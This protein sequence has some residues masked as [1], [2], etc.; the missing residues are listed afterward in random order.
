MTNIN[1]KV[2]GTANVSQMHGAFG[3]LEA[4]IAATNAQL[5]SMVNLQKG[6][7]GAGF[8][9]AAHAA[10]IGN[11]AF[12]NAAASTGMFEQMQLRVNS[13][14]DDYVKK[15]NAQ[16]LSFRDMIKQRKIAAAVL[17]E[18]I[19]LENSLMVRSDGSRNSRGRQLFDVS[20]AREVSS[21]LKTS[22]ARMALFNEQLKSG[23]HQMVNWGKNT[24]WA[25]RQLMVGFTIPMAA[26]AATAGVFAYQVDK[27]LTRI[28]KVYDTTAN[29]MSNNAKD[30]MAVEKELMAL[31]EDAMETTLKAAREYGA[32]GTDTL[33]VQADLAATGIKGVELQKATTEAMRIATLGELDYQQAVDTTIALQTAF[34]LNT[35]EL[36]EAFNFMNATENATSLSIQDIAEATPRAASAMSALGVSVEQMTVLLVAMRESG[37]DAAEAA[38]ALKS[39]TGT[40]LAPSPSADKFIKQ[41]TDGR[42]EI[43]KLAEASG[44]NLF[45]AMQQLFEQMRGLEQFEKQQILVKLFGKYQFNR[46]SALLYN[47]SDAIEG[48]ENQTHT[49]FE[50][51]GKDTADFAKTA[52]IELKRYQD[53]VS[54]RFDTTLQELKVKMAGVGE[55]FVEIATVVLKSVSKILDIFES[56]PGPVQ[57]T[58]GVILGMAAL[59]GPVIMLTG[60]FANLMGNAVKLGANVVGLGTKMKILD[61]ESRVAQLAAEKLNTTYLKET[62]AVQMLTAEIEK[63][64]LAQKEANIVMMQATGVPVP[65]SVSLN[66]PEKL[67]NGKTV[68]VANG[69]AKASERTAEANKRTS[70]AMRA[71][72]A[73]AAILATSFVAMSNTSDGIAH[74]ISQWVLNAS[75]MAPIIIEIT[76]QM[77]KARA[78]QRAMNAEAAASNVGLMAKLRGATGIGGKG[79][80]IGL[81]IAGIAAA[82][83]TAHHFW[84]KSREEAEKL[85]AIRQKQ[86]KGQTELL[87]VT[88]SWAKATGKTLEN[89]K[90][91]SY[92]SGKILSDAQKTAYQ[93]SFDLYSKG[94]GKEESKAFGELDADR[95][96]V[97]LML[98]FTELTQRAGLSIEEARTQML[99]FSAAS[100][101]SLA[102]ANSQI[103]AFFSTV[104]G[105]GDKKIIS[106]AY[107]QQMDTFLDLVSEG[108]DEKI[109]KA[110]G[111]KAG[112]LWAAAFSQVGKNKQAQLGKQLIEETSRV[113]EESFNKIRQQYLDSFGTRAYDS[114]SSE[115]RMMLS[116]YEKFKDAWD[117]GSLMEEL[118]KLKGI[119]SG[120]GF[121]DVTKIAEELTVAA[122][123]W[124][125]SS[126]AAE[127]SLLKGLKNVGLIADEVK[128]LRQAFADPYVFRF[129]GKEQQDS[130]LSEEVSRFIK[131]KQ[132]L[133]S[134]SEVMPSFF[135][136]KGVQEN[137]DAMKEKLRELINAA[138][139][140]RGFA[141]GATYEEAMANLINETKAAKSEVDNLKKAANDASGNYKMYFDIRGADSATIAKMA[142]QAM[143]DIQNQ[144][145]D[146]YRDALDARQEAA[147][148][149]RQAFWDKQAEAQEKK[150]DRESEAQ[151]KRFERQDKKLDA[152]FE[153]RTDKAEKYWDSRI[154][155]VDKA[156]EAEEAA[157]DLRKKMFDAEMQRIS[158]LNDSMNRNIDFNVALNEGRLD[159]AAKIRN[160]IFSTATSSALE[161]ARDAGSSASEARVKSLKENIDGLEEER[162]AYMDNLKKKEEAEKEHLK[163]SQERQS[164]ALKNQQDAQSKALKA[165][166]D[167]DIKSLRRA[168]EAEQTSLQQRLAMFMNYIAQNEGDLKRHMGNVGLTYEE[169][170]N[171][172]LHPK[173]DKWGGWYGKAMKRS[174]KNAALEME[175]DAMWEQLA[176]VSVKKLV[177]GMGFK[178]KKQFFQFVEDAVG[179]NAGS[180]AGDFGA[181]PTRH[182]GGMINSDPG[183]RKGVAR[184]TRGL[185]PTERMIRAQDGEFMVNKRA[186]AENLGLLTRINSGE[187]FG[188]D[189]GIGGGF[190]GGPLG[191]AS[192]PMAGISYALLAGIA[193]NLRKSKTDIDNDMASASYSGA[194]GN[195]TYTLPGVKPWVFEAAQYLGNKFDIAS[196]LG[197]GSRSRMSDHPLGLAL[198]FMTSDNRGTA[199]ANEV[200]RINKALDSTYVIWRQ[201]INSFDGQGWRPMA[202][203]GSPTE[204]HM[205]HVHVSFKP[206]GK[207]GDL[208]GLSTATGDFKQGTGGKHRPVNGG[209]ITQGLHGNNAVDFGVPRG[210]PV[211]AYADGI[212]SSSRDI[213]GPLP[214]DRYRGDGPYG[215]YGRVIEIN[216]GGFSTMYAHLGQRYA[217]TGQA[218]KGGAKIGLS[219]NTGNSSGP[220]LHFGMPGARMPAAFL[221]KG[222]TVKNDGTPAILHKDE[223]V[224]TAPLTKK[225]DLAVDALYNGRF[226]IGGKGDDKKKKKKNKKG[227]YD[228]P[229]YLGAWESI[230]TPQNVSPVPTPAAP[231]PIPTAWLMNTPFT[232]PEQMASSANSPHTW[233][234]YSSDDPK[235]EDTTSNSNPNSGIDSDDLASTIAGNTSTVLN[236]KF[237][238][239]I[240][241]LN[242]K[243]DVPA[244]QTITDIKKLI[245]MADVMTL[246]EMTRKVGPVRDFL[247]KKG[248]GLFSGTSKADKANMSVIAYNKAKYEASE[249]GTQKLG[250]KMG[251]FLGGREYRYANY[252][253][254]RNKETG[255][256][257]WQIAAHTVPT[258]GPNLKGKRLAMYNEQWSALDDLV[259]R[260][261]GTGLPV[262]L[263]GD[264]NNAPGQKGWRTPGGLDKYSGRNVDYIFSNPKLAKLISEQAINGMHTDHAGAWLA[265]YKIPSLSKGA[266]DVRY[267]DTLANLHR[268]E[269]VLT[270]DINSQ[271]RQGVENFANG[272][273]NQYTVQ[274]SITE[275]GATADEI[276]NK[277][278]TKLER[279]ES[280]RPGSRRNS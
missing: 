57:K 233:F 41:V 242:T 77:A 46:V 189:F 68:A 2:V 21:E 145:A 196:I 182:A 203:R 117:N 205:D 195:R 16:K 74:D 253:K 128:S 223:R 148:D 276:V 100:G 269:A 99:A 28:A 236:K 58:I 216:H 150:F 188:T 62:T 191:P 177:K 81:A 160:D 45:V 161:N 211:H 69:V 61:V 89:Y 40:I 110:N 192:V 26:A 226:G 245:G 70:T 31:R 266:M 215:S 180:A 277:V 83:I 118:Y 274:M 164:K 137:L 56:L 202:D 209:V 7:D 175:S 37:V 121:K 17:K 238:A 10:E 187:R 165:R 259:G 127:E 103:N 193:H 36:T 186:T 155:A 247:Q 84:S 11:K 71:Q 206:I 200:I 123:E 93:Q 254:L 15:L 65:R 29:S 181:A 92:N 280:R 125:V 124:K 232:Y 67:G 104:Q 113:S 111:I 240:A 207:T 54:G 101:K 136:G 170:G 32:V 119:G 79:G 5:A 176:N 66:V 230:L 267:D 87:N 76:R 272:G 222:G 172:V 184:T 194:T 38:N 20:Y 43:T 166:S 64:A 250:D 229:S 221:K 108:A 213:S 210:T 146:S 34:R 3:K 163:K 167:A 97:Q 158:K 204:N 12:R 271:F 152:K 219:G 75:L 114:M 4:Q 234:S 257:F 159:E 273:G 106:S 252:L 174:L 88:E 19:A 90:M 130:I 86:I 50:L 18:Q 255:G 135:G 227:G 244:A 169:F 141:L 248:W 212:V 265:K 173:A 53:S 147:M 183:S 24:Q 237:T 8:A 241:N 162:K 142:K 268:G 138:N 239:A 95:Q 55:P 260:L 6:V 256:K 14:T 112:E 91:I 190:E 131:L 198:D 27:E 59:A 1:V 228:G 231:V 264:L 63:M 98:M 168:Q 261:G 143:T 44:G 78:A 102:Q 9:R 30:I 154:E 42:I 22:S 218:I 208:P 275:P 225:L 263:G 48:V 251:N 133:E 156:I 185:H 73:N 179:K 140:A 49:A 153:R 82:G 126:S 217:Q 85:E 246:T 224:L 151:E 120:N 201:R 199:L 144:I 33:K 80:L 109:I 94:D 96:R 35:E 134:M 47:M 13:A 72:V 52:D 171:N 214:S 157:E 178:G 270:K 107:T 60:L 129:L 258:S 132:T 249:G 122:G 220:H 115:L 51:M 279:L 149:S 235:P 262:F 25:G 197:V 39:A 139:D 116:D 105:W 243:I 278:V 23:A